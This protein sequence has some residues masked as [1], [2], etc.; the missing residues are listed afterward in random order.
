MKTDIELRRNVLDE[1]E[2]EPSIDAAQI[3]VTAHAVR[4]AFESCHVTNANF[5]RF[6]PSRSST[7][8]APCFTIGEARRT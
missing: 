4:R 2:W 5:Q 7:R 3:G 1:I 8:N 6:T